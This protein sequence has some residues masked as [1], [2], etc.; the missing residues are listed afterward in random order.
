M[1]LDALS[2]QCNSPVEFVTFMPWLCLCP[3]FWCGTLSFGPLPLQCLK[4]LIQYYRLHS[5]R[6]PTR[7]LYIPTS[8]QLHHR[9]HTCQ[10]WYLLNSNFREKVNRKSIWLISIGQ[11]PDSHYDKKDK[12]TGPMTVEN[13]IVFTSIYRKSASLRSRDQRWSQTH[14]FCRPNP[15]F[16]RP[17]MFPTNC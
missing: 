12:Y 5:K 16:Y 13:V 6:Y 2:T 7:P 11:L 17:I 3:Q 15:I 10:T 1:K 8:Q 14:L 9:R 4:A